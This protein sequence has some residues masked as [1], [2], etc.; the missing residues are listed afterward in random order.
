MPT[1]DA[2]TIKELKSQKVADLLEEVLTNAV[3]DIL[4]RLA[5][6]Q[7]LQPW[8]ICYKTDCHARDDIPF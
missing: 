5:Q 2:E 6:G 7:K 8:M 3:L 1:L 4:T